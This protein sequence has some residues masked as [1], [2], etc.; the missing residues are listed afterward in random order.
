MPTPLDT[1]RFLS[2]TIGPRP[3]ASVVTRR[4][5]AWI[6][7]Q[8]R[9]AGFEAELQPFRGLATYSLTYGLLYGAFVLAAWLVAPAPRLAAALAL[10]AAWAFRGEQTYR[11]RLSRLLPREEGTNVVARRPAAREQRQT[12]VLVGHLDT[13][14]VALLFHPAMVG[15][16][17]LSFLSMLASM[18][19][20]LGTGI[21]ET[22]RR[23][24]GKQTR[25]APVPVWMA[26]VAAGYLTSS[27]L[28]IVHR[29]LFLGY[30]PGA[31]D[32][33]SGTAALLTAAAEL[34]PLD[35]AALWVVVTD[36]EETGSD[37]MLAFLHA[38]RAVLDPAT[39]FFIN[40]DNVGAGRVTVASEEGS[41]KVYRPDPTLLAVAR[42]VI[43]AEGLDATVGPYRLLG[44]D[45]EAAMEHGFRALSI[46]ALNEQGLL[47]N[48]H[49][50][51][52]TMEKIEPATVATAVRLV[53]GM[54]RA[55][56]GRLETN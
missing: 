33:A 43:A 56:H 28:F 25:P 27:L 50:K 40:V 51:T 19:I 22:L 21:A 49:W 52:D 13:H 31:N 44:T 7:G 4:A 17:R 32:N 41:L 24:R 39:T 26:R 55:L 18:G 35:H 36:C 34:P 38:H 47:P 16:F 6:A 2:E 15:G 42:E 45:G 46:L 8:L 48:W 5:A 37:G 23:S 10:L 12:I 3:S 9:S 1:I 30:T 20:I 53:A 54:V 29:H 11:P 14:H